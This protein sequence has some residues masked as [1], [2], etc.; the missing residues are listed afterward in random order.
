MQRLTFKPTL[1]PH[2][3]FFLGGVWKSS[4]YT[5]LQPVRV[6]ALHSVIVALL[7]ETWFC[8]F[9]AHIRNGGKHLH[10]TDERRT[11]AE[12]SMIRTT[13]NSKCGNRQNNPVWRRENGLKAFYSH[14]S[15]EYSGMDTV[16]SSMLCTVCVFLSGEQWS[17]SHPSC[18]FSTGC[19]PAHVYHHSRSGPCWVWW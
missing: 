8:V 12:E 17:G 10:F 13:T 11:K 15:Q 14:S 4:F 7:T 19:L 16:H 3:I 2:D 5:S 6:G 9:P 18:V 1:M